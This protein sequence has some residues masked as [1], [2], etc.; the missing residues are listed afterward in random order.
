MNRKFSK[1]LPLTT[2]G[3]VPFL[4]MPCSAAEAEK[5]QT[6]KRPNVLIVLLD[7]LGSADVG[8]AG[9]VDIPTP[10][11]DRIAKSGVV[12]TNAYISA[13]Y[14]GPSRCGLMT[15]RY[16]Q[17][18]GAEGN[19]ER[20]DEA[21]TEDIG[22]PLS[23]VLMSNVM[24]GNGYQTCAI[25]KW[26]LGDQE[27][28]LP[29]NRGFDYFYGFSG[30]GHSFWGGQAK[31]PFDFVQENGRKVP[32]E[33][34]TYLTDD[35]TDKAIDY[36]NK[37][38]KEDA[39]FFMY[40][41]YNAPHAPLQAPMKYLDRTTHIANAQRSVYAAM[42]LAVDDGLGRIWETLEK[43]KVDD[44]TLIVFLSDNG[45][46]GDPGRSSN[47]PYRSFKGNM[48]G[49]GIRTPFAVYWKGKIEAGT[50][51]DKSVSSLD[52]FPTVA[53]AAG[54]DVSKNKNP[55]DG[56]NLLPYITGE[57]SG[58]PHESLCW[59]VCGGMEYAILQGD[60][61]LVKTHYDEQHHLYN[62]KEDKVEMHNI[63]AEKPALVKAMLADYKLWDAQMIAPRWE[64]LHEKHQRI[65]HAAWVDYRKKASGGK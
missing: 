35:F 5:S 4:A 16:Q 9:C 51:Y 43:N 56:T 39:P 42:I 49:G 47:R 13:P 55:L 18:F 52:I 25:G 57:K 59:R 44:N 46:T 3:I 28:L 17:R 48:F 15:G 7:D 1:Y 11:I 62:V 20:N 32:K 8:F 54:I 2:V 19:I 14:S 53:A 30:G 36:I 22:V 26:H 31:F 58:D 60:Y 50:H 6:S 37:S 34:T 65:D 63:A 21:L 23:E 38:T 12:C 10:H 64:D 40:L 33:E 45:G 24:K 61:K 29:Q 27:K 41:A